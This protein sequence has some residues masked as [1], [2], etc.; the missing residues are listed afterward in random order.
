MMARDVEINAHAAREKR[1][2]ECHWCGSTALYRTITTRG[3]FASC[4]DH[5][6]LLPPSP[7]SIFQRKY[8]R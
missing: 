8:G 7:A 6:S 3:S 2:Q 4:A 5:R 1:R